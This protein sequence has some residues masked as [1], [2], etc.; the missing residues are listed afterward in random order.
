MNLN[1]K[2]VLKKVS[3]WKL[4][5]RCDFLREAKGIFQRIAGSLKYVVG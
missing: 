2:R 5:D 1:G 4:S 3:N